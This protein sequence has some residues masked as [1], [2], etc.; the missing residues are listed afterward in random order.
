MPLS[1][2]KINGYDVL[3][4]YPNNE[5]EEYIIHLAHYRQGPIVAGRDYHTTVEKF[6]DALI[7]MDILNAERLFEDF[8]LN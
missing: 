2:E 7:I 5:D 6:K 1:Q 3:V 4:H 8:N